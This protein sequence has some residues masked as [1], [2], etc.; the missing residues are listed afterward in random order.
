M[1]KTPPNVFDRPSLLLAPVRRAAYS[2]RTAWLMAS[3]SE[4]AYWQFEGGERVVDVVTDL[5]AEARGKNKKEA[6]ADVRK[7]LNKFLAT[8]GNTA[9]ESLESLRSVLEAAG[10]TLDGQY[11]ISETQGF[12]CHKPAT[13]TDDGMRI[14]AFRGTETKLKDFW[15]DLDATLVPAMDGTGQEKVHNGFQKAFDAVR[16]Q[17]VEDLSKNANLPLYVTGHSLGGALAVMATWFIASDSLGACYTFGGPRV[18]NLALEER[19]KTPIYRVV[20][21]ADIVPRV[22]PAFIPIL[23]SLLN[24]VPLPLDWLTRFLTRYAGYVHFGDMRYLT[25]V[26]AGPDQ[27]FKDLKLL[28]NP[29][30]MLRLGWV[31]G[32]WINT[33][34]KGAVSDHS[35]TLYRLKLKAYAI[36]KN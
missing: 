21:A 23:I 1:S 25:H 16:T 3:M 20:N 24:W 36:A 14:L 30:M 19:F 27:G 17:V 10:F 2:D 32:R 34:G 18:G 7:R 12:L 33:W 13:D 28:S 15:A 22:P 8:S 5:V 11:N 31:F 9:T 4:L 35:I 26:E 6:E 29:S